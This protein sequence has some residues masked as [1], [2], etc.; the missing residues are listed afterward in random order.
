MQAADKPAKVGIVAIA[1]KLPSIHKAMVLKHG[2]FA[3]NRTAATSL[4]DTSPAFDEGGLPLVACGLGRRGGKQ[5]TRRL[6]TA[7]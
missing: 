4:R 1:R 5:K 6:P 3:C 2:N 7:G